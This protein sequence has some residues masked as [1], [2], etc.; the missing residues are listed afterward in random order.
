MHQPNVVD[1]QKVYIFV[2]PIDILQDEQLLQK[3]SVHAGKYILMNK[4]Y[5]W[6]NFDCLQPLMPTLSKT[7]FHQI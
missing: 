5:K 6:S 1:L 3:Q 4:R 2:F 7:K